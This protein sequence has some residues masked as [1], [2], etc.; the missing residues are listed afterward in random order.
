MIIKQ[1]VKIKHGY[2]YQ[3]F[4]RKNLGGF[5]LLETMVAIAILLV[6]VTGPISIIGDSLH[7]LYY[8]R[9]Q[10]VAVNLAQ[11]GIESVRTTAETSMLN[12][13]DVTDKVMENATGGGSNFVIDPYAVFQSGLAEKSLLS[14]DSACI[15]TKQDVYL[16][17]AIGL[18]R[19]DKN[20]PSAGWTKTQFK[21]LVTNTEVV[22]GK[23]VKIESKVTWNTGGQQGSITVTENIFNWAL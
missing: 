19:Q 6:A 12:N 5:T 13:K 23:E 21:R 1:P 14:C 17:S 22:A 15:A 2:T 18:Y 9:D 7:K 3:N 20:S 10:M 11:E 4:S 16:D 8:A